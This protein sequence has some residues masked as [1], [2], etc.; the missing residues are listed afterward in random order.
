M[1]D[2]V[3]LSLKRRVLALLF[4]LG[5]LTAGGYHYF[6]V[7]DTVRPLSQCTATTCIGKID[8][9]TAIP[10]GRYEIRD[11]YSPKFK[12]KVLELVGVP[13]F[14]GIRIHSGNTAEDTEGCLI[15]GEVQTKNGV[16]QSAKAM[17]RF[18]KF[19]RGELAQGKRV[20]LTIQ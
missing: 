17:A 1:A 12:R 5:G 15:L 3:E 19:V 2:T 11:T 13:G 14:Q 7:E 16:A 10:P 4:T 20:Y 8:G 9:K 6:T 18:N